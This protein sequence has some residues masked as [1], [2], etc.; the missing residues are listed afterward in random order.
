MKLNWHYLM[1]TSSHCSC[2]PLFRFR[3][4]RSAGLFGSGI[5]TAI[6]QLDFQVYKNSICHSVWLELFGV[7]LNSHESGFEFLVVGQG[8]AVHCPG[9]IRKYNSSKNKGK[10]KKSW[11]LR[12][13]KDP[14]PGYS[15]L[16]NIGNFQKVVRA[17]EMR[18]PYK[19]IRPLK[20]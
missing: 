17:T 10:T 16:V 18:V 12:L 15:E 7:G 9:T 6:E 4:I 1:W 5:L 11:L 2:I 3:L 8:E 13:P 20:A 19:S 14:N